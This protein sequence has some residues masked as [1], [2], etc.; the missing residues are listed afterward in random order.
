MGILNLQTLIVFILFV[1]LALVIDFLA[2]KNDE[3]I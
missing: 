2:H 1:V 3:K